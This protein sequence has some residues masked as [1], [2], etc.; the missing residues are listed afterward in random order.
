M[1]SSWWS[2]PFRPFTLIVI[3]TYGLVA[4]LVWWQI[5]ILPCPPPFPFPV[6]VGVAVAVPVGVGLAVA[7]V[8]G[9]GVAVEPENVFVMVQVADEVV[10]RMITVPL[11][12]HAP[13]NVAV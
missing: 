9:V 3:S 10:A 8:V 4:E 7:V 11:A 12:S 5:V 6:G 13:A 2:W 1:M